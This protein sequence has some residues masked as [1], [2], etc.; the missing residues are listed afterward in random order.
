MKAKRSAELAAND[1]N[2]VEFAR[3]LDSIGKRGKRLLMRYNRFANAGKADLFLPTLKK[4]ALD[5]GWKGSFSESKNK[6][7]LENEHTRKRQ[8]TSKSK[9]QS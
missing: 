7:K 2:V 1:P 4:M 9:T 8:T 5:T 6:K 3:Y